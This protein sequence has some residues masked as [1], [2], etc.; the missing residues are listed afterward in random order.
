MVGQGAALADAGA[1]TLALSV[2]AAV[3]C[4]IAWEWRARV[5]HLDFVIAAAAFGGLGMALATEIGG[6]AGHAAH[7]GPASHGY[8]GAI[9]GMLIV[10]VP[11]CAWRCDPLT[12]GGFAHRAFAHLIAIVGMLAGMA[13]GGWAAGPWLASV[14]GAAAGMHVAMVAGMAAG[15]ALSLPAV[16]LLNRRRRDPRAADC[17]LARSGPCDAVCSG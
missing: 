6:D 7:G 1:G 16:A 4:A 3:L 15:T 17:E 9:V 12:G 10:C 8:G 5:P 13:A 14:L 11:A 2:A